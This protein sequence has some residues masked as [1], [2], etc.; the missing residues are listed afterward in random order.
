MNVAPG[1]QHVRRPEKIAAGRGRHEPAVEC[2]DQPVEFTVVGKI[3]IGPHQPLDQRVVLVAATAC[4]IDGRGVKIG[5][6][7]NHVRCGR[8]CLVGL[9]DL[10]QHFATFTQVHGAAGHVQPVRDQRIFELQHRGRQLRHVAVRVARW[11]GTVEFKLLGLDLDQVKRLGPFFGPAF[12]QIAQAIKRSLEFTQPLVEPGIGHR[13]RQVGNKRCRR[14]ALGDRA[15]GRIVGGI[16]VEVR[17]IPDQPVGPALARH[18]RLLAGHEL[19]RAMSAEM[20]NCIGAEM[21]LE[22]GVE[23]GKRM[24]RRK[25]LLKQEPHRVTLVAEAR[26]NRDQ[27]VAELP[28]Q[29]ENRLAVGEDPAGCWP[30][31]RLDLIKVLFIAD[32]IIGAHQ[33]MHIGECAILRGIAV[34][35][36]VAQFLGVGGNLDRVA[37]VPHPEHRRMQRFKH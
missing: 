32:M 16:E 25:A 28:S 24:G 23:G 12:I 17:Q 3:G 33:R 10:G 7:V 26:L 29:H 11:H 37:L 21:A 4:G 5:D 22:I 34:E 6:R 20:Q 15:F 30:P 31:L 18:A 13:R 27:Y 9:G 2:S 14:A 8:L 35:H 36:H 1:G 19:E